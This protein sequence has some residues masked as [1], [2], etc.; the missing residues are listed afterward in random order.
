MSNPLKLR[1][2]SYFHWLVEEIEK[3][4][5]KEDE[6]EAIE[7]QSAWRKKRIE[8]KI[9]YEEKKNNFDAIPSS[10]ESNNT[11]LAEDFGRG[12]SSEPSVKSN[13]RFTPLEAVLNYQ[14]A[15]CAATKVLSVLLCHRTH[16]N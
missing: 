6:L 12:S 8:K 4:L 13:A 7:S 10:D 11:S 1:K 2:T 14:I 16:L 5:G 9:N 15:H 3:E